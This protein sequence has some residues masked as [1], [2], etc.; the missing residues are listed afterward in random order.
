[1]RT[2][3]GEDER[4][5]EHLFVAGGSADM[6]AQPLREISVELL[7]KLKIEPHKVPKG[8]FSCHILL[9]QF[10]QATREPS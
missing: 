3:A 9:K 6:Y 8:S 5:M 7:K 1:M 10:H 2:Y 4:K